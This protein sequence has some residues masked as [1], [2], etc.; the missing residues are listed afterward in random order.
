M[1]HSHVSQIWWIDS[2]SLANRCALQ[3][4]QIVATIYGT[5]STLSPK[6]RRA[7]HPPNENCRISKCENAKSTK[8]YVCLCLSNFTIKFNLHSFYECFFHFSLQQNTYN[9]SL[10]SSFPTRLRLL[11][12]IRSSF[13]S[14]ISAFGIIRFSLVSPGRHGYIRYK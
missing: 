9:F 10:F 4:C 14:C 6:P 7:R 12:P 13:R 11:P 8:T 2:I 1:N 3:W 5:R